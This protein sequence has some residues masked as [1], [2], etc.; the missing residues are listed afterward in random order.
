MLPSRLCSSALRI[1]SLPHL[2]IALAAVL[3]ASVVAQDRSN[4]PRRIVRTVAPSVVLITVFD[5]TGQPLSLGSGFVS[6][7]STVVT[8]RHVVAGGTRASVKPVGDSTLRYVTSML[9]VDTVHDLVLLA[10]RDLKASAL[11]LADSRSVEVGQRVLAIGNPRGL[12]GTVSE[13]IVSGIRS[14]GRDTLLQ[15]TAPISPGSSGGPVVDESGQVIGVA[16][17]AF[18]DGQNLNF[19]IPSAY[20]AELL[21]SSHVSR[22]LSAVRAR[23]TLGGIFGRGSN[24]GRSGVSLTNFLWTSDPSFSRGWECLSLGGQCEYT[25][26]IRNSLDQPI[27]RV[28]YLVVFYDRSGQP[29][30]ADESQ[31]WDEV[32]RPGL[33]T[34]V[35]RSVDT[36]VR[37]LT[38]RVAF[39]VL[40]FEIVP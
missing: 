20:V 38:V 36:S 17:G 18:V 39:R 1:D 28:K 27:R 4:D 29:I 10:V 31:T 25:F 22:P 12:E 19:A 6:S 5:A 3:P 33:A 15:I 7:E 35:I 16:V 32:I 23:G 14:S 9:A 13:G 30:D 40:D 37:R 26:S 11:S 2:I 21:A 34:R 8:N 24:A